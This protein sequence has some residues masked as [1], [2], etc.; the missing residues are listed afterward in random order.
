[1]KA[2]DRPTLGIS[3]CVLS[4]V[5]MAGMFISVKAVSDD[6][7]LGQ[8]VFFRSFFAILPLVIF[9]WMRD[10]F[11]SGLATKRPSAHFLRASFGASA[12]FLTPSP[13]W[14]V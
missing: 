4:G 13:L 11:P 9:L 1:M 14:R 3:L 5:L 7:P 6:I 8:I 10:E 12:F 2:L